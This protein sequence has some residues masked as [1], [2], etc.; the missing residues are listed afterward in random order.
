MKMRGR[1][2]VITGGTSGIGRELVEQLKEDNTISVIGRESSVL[3]D[4]R[5][6]FPELRIFTADLSDL[7]SVTKAAQALIRQS[8]AIDVLINNAGVQFTPKFTD[9]E[10]DVDSIQ[11]EINTNFTSICLLIAQCLPTLLRQDQSI[12]LNVNSGLGLA[13]KTNSAVYCGTKG[14]LN[15]FSQS[16]RY[17][18]EASNVRVMQAFLPLVDTKM[19]SGRGS[20]KITAAEAAKEIIAGIESRKLDFGIG[21]AKLL[22]RILRVSPSV[23]KRIMKA[24]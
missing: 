6:S 21:K 23:A 14:G 10:F 17:Q 18:L 22:M 9:P 4:L 20:G 13:P 16:L 19:T 2:I 8:P 15:L 3:E 5:V 12:I 24:A 7:K 11:K 1:H